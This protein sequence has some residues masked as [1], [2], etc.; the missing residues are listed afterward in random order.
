[1]GETAANAGMVFYGAIVSAPD[2]FF[3]LEEK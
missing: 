2:N 3:G 1:M